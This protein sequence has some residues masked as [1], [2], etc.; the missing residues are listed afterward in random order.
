MS[1]RNSCCRRLLLDLLNKKK[2]IFLQLLLILLTTVVVETMIVNYKH[3]YKTSS[4]IK[5][6]KYRWCRHWWNLDNSSRCCR[7]RRQRTSNVILTRL[8]VVQRTAGFQFARNTE[9]NDNVTNRLEFVEWLQWKGTVANVVTI[10]ATKTRTK[11]S[12]FARGDFGQ[13]NNNNKK[14]RDID[15]ER[16][17]NHRQS[18]TSNSSR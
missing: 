3:Q 15:T 9:T 11:I 16:S 1:F 14:W 17:P 2:D 12:V 4:I 7:R 6:E 13:N 10:R 8:A 5:T 18:Y